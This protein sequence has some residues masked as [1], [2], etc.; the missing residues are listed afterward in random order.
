[1]QEAACAAAISLLPSLEP[2]LGGSLALNL[3]YL[4]LSKFAY[5]NVVKASIGHRLEK[6]KDDATL[7]NRIDA[8]Q[9]Y[10]QMDALANV[11]TLDQSLPGRKKPWVSAPGVWGFF[12][13][14]LFYWRLGRAVS[15]LAVVYALSLLILGVGHASGAI[16]W[17]RCYFDESWIANDFTLATIGL[18][19]PILMVTAGTLICT[20]ATHFVKYQTQN[21]K[22][23]AV[24]EAR[25]AL[26]ESEQAVTA[27]APAT[28]KK[29]PAKKP[30]AATTVPRTRRRAK[31]KP[32]AKPKVTEGA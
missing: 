24:T 1:M 15:I 14:I 23:A 19:W 32:A 31:R 4:N 3:A 5:I 30:T 25:E 16:T 8:T 21:L 17:G 10:R 9:W 28:P 7:R 2:V 6:V 27:A 20:A 22:E 12:Y 18:I 13:N 11:E 26:T 29:P